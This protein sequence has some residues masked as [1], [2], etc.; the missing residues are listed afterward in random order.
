MG[1]LGNIWVKLGLKSDD[2]RKG[3]DQS[4]KKVGKFG[5]ATQKM[6]MLAKAAWAAVGAAIA[7][8]VVDMGKVAAEA[9]GVRQAFARIADSRMLEQLRKATRG[10]VDDVMLMKKAVQASNFGIP[11]K[12]LAGYF[13]FATTRAIQTGESV[14]Y[15]VD[16]IITG[17]GR[18]SVMI[19]DN[20]G[21]SAA[22]IRKEME[23]TGDMASAVGIIIK[24]EMEKTGK[25]ADT[26]AITLQQVKAS[27][28]NVKVSFGSSQVIQK[29][30]MAATRGQC[31]TVGVG[32]GGKRRGR[33]LFTH[34]RKLTV[35]KLHRRNGWKGSL[36]E[37]P[38]FRSGT[39]SLWQKAARSLT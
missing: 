31:P 33:K 28:E 39:K 14:D 23:K 1:V 5:K 16:S 22:D 12:E 4:E 27:W 38:Q 20:L 21:I 11:I 32:Q 8:I 26:G 7:K 17:L 30:L 3:M 6:S 18:K 2:F 15:L 24:R 13:E 9:E 29:T 10:T 35:Q 34:N 37:E 36:K 19:L 25:A